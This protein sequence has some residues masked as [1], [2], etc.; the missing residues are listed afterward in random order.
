MAPGGT[1]PPSHRSSLES[2][3]VFLIF[4]S[5]F[6]EKVLPGSCRMIYF[7]QQTEPEPP[8]RPKAEKGSRDS[9]PSCPLYHFLDPFLRSPPTDIYHE[10]SHPRFC[11]LLFES[12]PFSR[13]FR[14]PSEMLFRF[15]PSDPAHLFY[16][17][18]SLTPRRHSFSKKAARLFFSIPR[19]Y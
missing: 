1:S 5:P 6:I 15:F 8:F 19:T 7:F 3:C 12:L 14:L 16:A 9:P 2:L 18:S 10:I 17:P 4:P 11:N 13:Y